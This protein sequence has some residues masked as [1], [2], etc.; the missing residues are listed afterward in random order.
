MATAA[1]ATKST[2]GQPPKLRHT[3][4][5]YLKCFFIGLQLIVF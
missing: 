4:W 1:P 5:W 3:F 2:P